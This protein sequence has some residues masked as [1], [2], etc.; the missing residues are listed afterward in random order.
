MQE[1]VDAVVQKPQPLKNEGDPE[2]WL[3]DV[4]Y[5]YPDEEEEMPPL[6]IDTGSWTVKA[7][8]SG[9]DGPRS[10]IPTVYGCPMV[11]CTMIGGDC[12]NV[13]IG[14][15]AICKRGILTLRWPVENGIVKRWG[16]GGDD[17]PGMEEI[18]HHT[19]CEWAVPV[20]RP[21]PVRAPHNTTHARLCFVQWWSKASHSPRTP[22]GPNVQSEHPPPR[23]FP[24]R[25]QGNELR[26]APD[27]HC[28]MLSD[29]PLNPRKNRERMTQIHFESF[30]VPSLYVHS[31]PAL[32]LYASGRTT[33][34]VLDTGAGAYFGGSTN[35]VPVC[36]C[37]PPGRPIQL[38]RGPRMPLRA[39][40]HLH[41]APT[42]R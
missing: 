36:A 29:S 18:W 12:K 4:G 28:V 20:R 19:Y 38:A 14:D 7:G 3:V 27:E 34:C 30:A 11:R 5:E 1:Y 32:A 25:P 33:G 22:P 8:F 31:Q 16:G 39:A 9:D 24:A 23:P 6:V 15:E 2:Q 17:D 41:N 35:A 40:L 10:C 42:C 21:P 37:L 13:Y 26:V